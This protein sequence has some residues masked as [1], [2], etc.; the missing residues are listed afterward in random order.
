MK[1]SLQIYL[2]LNSIVILATGLGMIV[3]GAEA[4]AVLSE[5]QSAKFDSDFRAL[6][7]L[8]AGYAFLI[9]WVIP[10][11][12]RKAV[13]LAIL[14]FIA[15]FAGIAR[16]VSV[17]K[18]GMAPHDVSLAIVLCFTAPFV[19]VWQ[20][21]AAKEVAKKTIN[22]HLSADG[23]LDLGRSPDAPEGARSATN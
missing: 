1:F 12:E 22:A 10:D 18:Y 4:V 21:F 7:A 20:Y 19:L 11:V 23:S 2:G 9:W 5:I 16:L 17:A 8:L 3:Y 6:G 15:T 14:S 13:P